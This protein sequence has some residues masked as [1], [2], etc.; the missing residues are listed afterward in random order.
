VQCGNISEGFSGEESNMANLDSLYHFAGNDGISL[1]TLREIRL[2]TMLDSIPLGSDIVIAHDLSFLGFNKHH[3][4]YDRRWLFN[5]TMLGYEYNLCLAI[6]PVSK[7][8]LGAAHDSITN[9]NGPD[10]TDMMDYNYEPLFADLDESE[11]DKLCL[12]HKHQAA[13][14][15]NGLAKSMKGYRRI[16]TLDREFDDVFIFLTA[17]TNS[18][19]YVIRATALRNVQMPK[20]EWLSE[21]AITKHQAGHKLEEGNVC[22]NLQQAV[23]DIPVESIRHIPL[24]KDGRVTDEKSA[25][26]IAEVGIGACPVTLYRSV[27]RNKKY[28]KTPEPIT[29]NM[30]VVRELNPPE[31]VEQLLWVLFTNLPIKTLEDMIRI[32]EYY[33]LR[34]RIEEYFRYI[35]SGFDILARRFNNAEKVAKYLLIISIILPEILNIKSM[36]GL[37]ASGKLDDK[38]YEELKEASENLNDP[39]ISLDLRTFAYICILGGWLGRRGDPIGIKIILK[40][41]HSLIKILSGKKNNKLLIDE[42]ERNNIFNL[43]NLY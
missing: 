21:E 32:V 39:S 27:K 35:K 31:G 34:W 8:I 16:H 29:V 2:K 24:D 9:I 33:E 20:Y 38:Q 13:V 30:V 10:D 4:K 19:Y 7:R 37:P 43:N 23:L 28:Y 17:Y 12:N 5:N 41:V 22:V 15:I 36:V 1:A 14:H 18:E 3:S 42:I 40:G 25:V 6:D 11:K 26:R